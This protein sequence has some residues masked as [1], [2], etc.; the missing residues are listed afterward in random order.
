MLALVPQEEPILSDFLTQPSTGQATSTDLPSS[1]MSLGHALGASLFY[2]ASKTERAQ[3][4]QCLE[5][6]EWVSTCQLKATSFPAS[7]LHFPKHLLSVFDDAWNP[8]SM[9]HGI[10]QKKSTTT[11]T[12]H[13]ADL[14]EVQR[15]MVQNAVDNQDVFLIQ[16]LPATGKRRIALEIIAQCLRR[17]ERV[18]LLTW[19]QDILES[20]VQRIRGAMEVACIVMGPN[21]SNPE[22]MPY[23]LASMADALLDTSLKSHPRLTALYERLDHCQHCLH[24]WPRWQDRLRRNEQMQMELESLQKEKQELS[25]VHRHEWQ[26]DSIQ[27]LLPESTKQV[28]AETSR[29]EAILAELQQA[30]NTA[31][32]NFL[33]QEAACGRWR[34]QV[35]QQENVVDLRKQPHWLSWR[36]WRVA[37][38]GRAEERLAEFRT[39]CEEAAQELIKK[40]Q[41]IDEAEQQIAIEHHRH[42]AAKV[43][44]LQMDLSLRIEALETK[45]SALREAREEDLRQW[46]ELCAS[47]STE[48]PLLPFSE[49]GLH[50]LRDWLYRALEAIQIEIKQVKQDVLPTQQFALQ[51]ELLSAAQLIGAAGSAANQLNR[52]EWTT[53]MPQGVD[54]L[55]LLEAEQWPRQE[56]LAAC[57]W[58]NQC[59]LIGQASWWP[60]H[61]VSAFHGL[62]NAW[63]QPPAAGSARWYETSTQLIC[64]L[65]DPAS[66]IDQ[67]VHWETLADQPAVELG[68][69]HA[70]GDVPHLASVV[71]PKADFALAT[72]KKLLTE[73]LEESTLDCQSRSL[74]WQFHS[75]GVALTFPEMVELSPAIDVELEPGLVE[76]LVAVPVPDQPDIVEWRTRKIVFNDPWNRERILDWVQHK[77]SWTEVGRVG[78]LDQRWGI[79]SELNHLVQSAILHKPLIRDLKERGVHEWLRISPTRLKASR[80]E[81]PS[82]PHQMLIKDAPVQSRFDHQKEEAQSLVAALEQWLQ[83][84]DKPCDPPL[85]VLVIT[86]ESTQ[87]RLLQELWHQQTYQAEESFS[88]EF[89]S[90]QQAQ[91]RHADAVFVSLWPYTHQDGMNDEVRYRTC[92]TALLAARNYLLWVGDL[93]AAL[94]CASGRGLANDTQPGHAISEATTH[95]LKLI[96]S[97]VGEPHWIVMPEGALA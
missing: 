41:A 79:K 96:Q 85:S 15:C 97:Q 23:S 55:I 50:Q 92:V 62:I 91:G 29:H 12:F 46:S 42:Q 32:M 1:M 90:A 7:Y 40:Q 27:H 60:G 57:S 94:A 37:W 20:L 28:E 69:I 44:I 33:D 18:L 93:A 78:T 54:R 48:W 83:K 43:Q 75:D 81:N 24:E 36:W 21:P 86:S 68:I 87:Q 63:Y 65:I 13:D 16:G 52:D 67:P 3:W 82:R 64:Q 80:Q 25:G 35:S 4:L 9:P 95:L 47:L 17:G 39:R 11:L 19:H 45:I 88:I 22:A 34:Q 59:V 6:G 51:A 66:C 8:S 14:S 89:L 71:F 26:I 77:L 10:N 73:H 2:A 61:T 31:K 72:A 76:N 30:V 38:Q 70:D 5:R 53:A 49:L 84:A 56:L 58:A 74:N